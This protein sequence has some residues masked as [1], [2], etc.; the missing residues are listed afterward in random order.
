MGGWGGGRDLGRKGEVRGVEGEGRGGRWWGEGNLG[1]GGGTWWR[2]QVF[3]RA[4]RG[5]GGWE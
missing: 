3:G 5:C 2:G 4:W 1:E